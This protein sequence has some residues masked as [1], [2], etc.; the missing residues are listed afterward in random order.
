MLCFLFLFSVCSFCVVVFLML[1]GVA[2]L[3]SLGLVNRVFR[4]S[5][6][7]VSA[8]EFRNRIFEMAHKAGVAVKQVYVLPESSSQL[9]NAF[10]RSDNAVMITASLLKN[11]SKRE[12]DAI[13]AHEIGHLKEKHPQIR[14]HITLGA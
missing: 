5:V 3:L 14:G 11:L 6:Y 1:A 12:V 9:S 10:A 4:F 13:M 7:A 8:G 2:C